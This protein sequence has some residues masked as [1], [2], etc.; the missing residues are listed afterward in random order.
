MKPSIC[1]IG[2]GIS[3]I[4]CTRWAK[5]L[6]LDITVLESSS[7]IGGC[8]YHK[9]YK[10]VKLQTTKYSYAFSDMPMDDSYQMHPSSDEVMDYLKKYTNH[11]NLLKYVN[12]QHKVVKIS[13]DN[14]WEIRYHNL[15]TDKV[16]SIFTDYLT[17]CSGLYSKPNIPSFAKKFM[18]PSSRTKPILKH[19]SID[20]YHSYQFSSEHKLDP[21]ILKGKNVVVIGNG[22]TGCDLSTLACDNCC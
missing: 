11:H 21:T 22:P 12:F 5:E 15:S 7:D 8:W 6:G 18:I 4:A 1:I 17:I 19:P 16:D 3:G 20:I 10:N 14:H 13:Y 2:F 9:N